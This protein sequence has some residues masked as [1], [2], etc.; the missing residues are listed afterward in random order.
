M[1]LFLSILVNSSFVEDLPP[2]VRRLERRKLLMIFKTSSVLNICQDLDIVKQ[3]Y[4]L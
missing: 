1:Y 2:L 4:I 3:L